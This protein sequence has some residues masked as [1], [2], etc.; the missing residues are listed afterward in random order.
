MLDKGKGGYRFLYRASQTFTQIFGESAFAGQ[1]LAADPIVAAQGGGPIVSWLKSAQ[2]KAAIETFF[3]K[4][5]TKTKNLGISLS[6]AFSVFRFFSMPKVERVYWKKAIPIEARKYIP[7]PLEQCYFDW[8]AVEIVVEGKTLLGVLFGAM[9]RDVCEAL[10]AL[11]DSVGVK[12]LF[13]DSLPFA[14]SRSLQNLNTAA[15]LPADVTAQ[16]LLMVYLDLEQVQLMLLHKGI[17][18]LLRSIYLSEAQARGGFTMERRKL[19]LQATIDFV[20]RQLGIKQLDR[21]ILMG[22]QGLD[23]ASLKNWA[24]G[25][26]EELGLKVDQI[27][28]LTTTLIVTLD[29]KTKPL[30]LSGWAEVACFG[31]GLRG[32]TTTLDAQEINLAAPTLEAPPKKTALKKIWT[33]AVV[34]SCVSLGLALWR[35]NEARQAQAQVERIRM[36]VEQDYPQVQGRDA[37]TLKTLVETKTI[38]SRILGLFARR[39][40]RVFVTSL[41]AS[42]A[43][44]IPPEA[45]LESFDYSGKIPT[46]A[47]DRGLGLETHWKLHGRV[48]ILG[49]QREFGVAQDFFKFLKEN[50]SIAKTFARTDISIKKEMASSQLAKGSLV[51]DMEFS[52]NTNRNESER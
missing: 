7:Y 6:E 30:E 17:P 22:A 43:N 5:P 19:D 16:T 21:V 40:S 50:P 18:V 46:E 47:L 14:I 38:S 39:Q 29:N 24:S 3:K 27:H 23:E 25:L 11:M 13:V 33:T 26:S 4:N 36:K 28:P 35:F 9:R 15:K 10:Q 34:V 31:L 20:H 1:T 44:C 41:L 8:R 51:F 45:W 52:N 37:A 32:V 42:L 12:I 2:M 48:G 49:N